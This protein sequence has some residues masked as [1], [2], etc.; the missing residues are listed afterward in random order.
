[1][2]EAVITYLPFL[3]QHG[4][5][6]KTLVGFTCYALGVGPFR[7]EQQFGHPQAGHPLTYLAHELLSLNPALSGD[8]RRFEQTRGNTAAA[9]EIL[10]Q[11]IRAKI[12]VS[13]QNRTVHAFVQERFIGGGVL[14]SFSVYEQEYL[15][16]PLPRLA[17]P[18]F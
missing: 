13:I 8:T 4:V 2:R 1:L 12:A 5:D 17:T 11:V 10:M 9:I 7:C 6:I 3:E 18:V 14:V 16:E 15:N